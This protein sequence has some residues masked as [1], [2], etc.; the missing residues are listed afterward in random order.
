MTE[1][2]VV[3]ATAECI[4]DKKS[5]IE[6]KQLKPEQRIVNDYTASHDYNADNHTSKT[7]LSIDSALQS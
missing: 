4:H 3:S 1:F 2:Y 7:D 5:Y 6:R